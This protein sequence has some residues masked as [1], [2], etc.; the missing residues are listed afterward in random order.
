MIIL[1]C[2]KNNSTVSDSENNKEYSELTMIVIT[3]GDYNSHRL[4]SL[5]GDTLTLRTCQS[6]PTEYLTYSL[7]KD[8]L[9]VKKV[10]GKEEVK[11]IRKIIDSNL[12]YTSGVRSW[13]DTIYYLYY[14]WKLIACGENEYKE[15]FP[16]EF[17]DIIE[18]YNRNLKSM[19]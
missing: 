7:N 8:F 2:T 1:S 17:R 16:K 5:S 19:E 15:S 9:P 4:L 12:Y 14:D 13:G 10:L 3:Q 11:E 18:I 6:Q